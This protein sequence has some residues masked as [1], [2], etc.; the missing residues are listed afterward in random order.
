[1]FKIAF[2]KLTFNF[3]FYFCILSNKSTELFKT[4]YRYFNNNVVNSRSYT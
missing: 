3:Y 4:N 1:M 2:Q